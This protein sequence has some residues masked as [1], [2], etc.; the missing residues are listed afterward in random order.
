MR[1]GRPSFGTGGI[2]PVGGGGGGAPGVTVAGGGVG[3]G[4]CSGAGVTPAAGVWVCWS[5]VWGAGVSSV[6][7]C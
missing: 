2:P 5:W 6:W 3:D 1:A 4:V 7:V